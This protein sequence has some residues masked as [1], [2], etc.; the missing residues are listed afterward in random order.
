MSSPKANLA[1][2][3]TCAQEPIRIPGKIQ[4]HGVLIALSGE[5]A[6]IVHVSFNVSRLG[7]DG[8]SVLGQRFDEAVPTLARQLQPLLDEV[9]GRQ[10]DGP[11][12]AIMI[13]L[14]GTGG[15]FEA[16]A[17][18]CGDLL[19]VELEDARAGVAT[20]GEP[21]PDLRAFV[22]RLQSTASL[23][24]LCALA[25]DEIRR[26]T[27]FDRVMVYRF[28]E[29][30]NGTV[31]GESRNDV[32]PSYLDL[33]F[34]ASD[35]PAQARELYRISPIRI[36]PDAAYEPVPILPVLT[37][38]TDKPLDLSFAA[39]RSVSPV[40]IE[41]MHN[42]GTRSSMSISILQGDRLWGLI[43][44]HSRE[45]RRVLPQIRNAC[46]FLAQIFALQVGA[47]EQAAS[48]THRMH[49][50]SVQTKLLGF[51]AEEDSFVSGLLEHPAE[52]LEVAEASGGAIV[53][54][55]SI[56]LIGEAPSVSEVRDLADW[57]RREH[58][59]DLVATDSLARDRGLPATETSP[60]AGLLAMSISQV[61]TDYV[62]WFRP[63]VVQTV[64]WGGD[65]TKAVS[66]QDGSIRL[67]PRKSF[68]IWRETV[69]GQSLPWSRNI[70]ETVRELRNA[71]VGIVLKRAEELAS[72][73]VELQRSNKELEAF[74]Y[75]V[76]HDLRAPF[77]HIV[78]YSEML[79]NQE[80]SR[81]SERG[82]RYIDTVIEAAFS[83][84]TLVDNL[85]SF[86]QMGRAT[87]NKR[88][89]DLNMIVEDVIR[90]MAPDIGD[91]QIDWRI[92]RLGSVRVDPVM[93]KL[94][95]E[96]LISNAVKYTRGR[97][98]A[99]IEIGRTDDQSES[100]IF[101][102]DNGAGFDM[103]Y[104]NKLFGVFQRLHRAEEFEGT[105]IG[106]AN[107]RRILERHSGRVW[108]EGALDQGATFHMALPNQEAARNG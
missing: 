26:M 81:L 10:E 105:G 107:V 18:R 41:Y 55:D 102:R 21:D 1:D 43:S 72:L 99:V 42:M 33:R 37:P 50:S 53:V 46:D 58:K 40:H 24:H 61:H 92:G 35:I 62:M 57:L 23:D 108:A 89:V 91:R 56:R 51:M 86:S 78:G 25:T 64:K 39:L 54:G 32:L 88:A 101:V 94:A 7:L 90:R 104:V 2:L 36:I 82:R 85:L 65:P 8:E 97:D 74:S 15:R 84:G 75:S 34:P 66:A 87:L 49:L 19:I 29:N 106:L 14:T 20:A 60:A 3:D 71:V 79:R 22:R 69:R 12:R 5:D 44:C 59:A 31:L 13:E 67:H 95:V 38:G 76:S 100:V 93:F 47:L 6:S 77:R 80:G 45:A 70:I 16:S 83:A 48:A 17:H 63:E 30:W 28:D 68:E 96:N 73:T 103:R 27:G 11:S 4:P 98:V 9:R 52:F